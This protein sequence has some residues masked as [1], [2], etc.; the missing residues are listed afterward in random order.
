M[1]SSGSIWLWIVDFLLVVA[2]WFLPYMYFPN[3][4]LLTKT[5]L[6]Y[7]RMFLWSL[8]AMQKYIAN[9][10]SK[11]QDARFFWNM[12]RMV[13]F[14]SIAM[15]ATRG[16]W[17]Y[18][19]YREGAATYGLDVFDGTVSTNWEIAKIAIC[20]A[21]GVLAA[22]FFFD[23]LFDS[24]SFRGEEDE[25]EDEDRRRVQSTALSNSRQ[26]PPKWNSVPSQGFVATT[27]QP[28]VS[29]TLNNG[30]AS[31][32]PMQPMWMS[33]A[34]PRPVMYPAGP[35]VQGFVATGGY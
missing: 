23:C 11:K 14:V 27:G 24:I 12:F 32:P 28:N 25:N 9:Q 29:V 35:M 26:Q 30:Q 19:M 31:G 22:L 6:V 8:Y 1:A 33:A 15:D 20:G 18:M 5:G 3:W 4:T 21:H 13:V 10:K 16:V 17:Q 34:Q 2:G 7:E